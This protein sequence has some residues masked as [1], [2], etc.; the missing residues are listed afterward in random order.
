MNVA[1]RWAKLLLTAADAYDSPSFAWDL[2]EL[3]CTPATAR[4]MANRWREI[5]FEPRA[6]ADQLD[7]F[8]DELDELLTN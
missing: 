8:A 4:L 3:G 2:A 7:A 5:P 1:G 6:F